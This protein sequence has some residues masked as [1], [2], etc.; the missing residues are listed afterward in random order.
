MTT[1]FSFAIDLIDFDNARLGGYW[2]HSV[3]GTGN[4]GGQGYT[5]IQFPRSMPRGENWLARR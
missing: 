3:T 4:G 2:Q 1:S 5:L